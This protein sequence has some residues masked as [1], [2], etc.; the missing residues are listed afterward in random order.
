[1]SSPIDTTVTVQLVHVQLSL[2]DDIV[3]ANHH[4]G[5]RTHEAG[6]AAEECKQARS[7]ALLHMSFVPGFQLAATYDDLP[8]IRHNTED[9]HKQRSTEDIDVSG[10]QTRD[11]V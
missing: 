9:R 6:I 4:T 5:K 2:L 1:M 7:I 8:W 3:I 11:I 10:C